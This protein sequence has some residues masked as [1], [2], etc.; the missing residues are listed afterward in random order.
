MTSP[1]LLTTE[2]VVRRAIDLVD[3]RG[4]TSGECTNELGKMCF[5]AAVA[6]IMTNSCYAIYDDREVNPSLDNVVYDIIRRLGL[7]GQKK[8]RLIDWNDR[9]DRWE[10]VRAALVDTF[11]GEE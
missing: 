3:A 8:M 2:E 1:S 6:E 10:D 11:F 4:W 5:G 7:S 9:F